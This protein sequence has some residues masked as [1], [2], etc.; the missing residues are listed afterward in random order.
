VEWAVLDWNTPTIGFYQALGA[1]P[2]EGWTTYRLT[3]T[4]LWDLARG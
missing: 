2:D 3:G 4:A 1:Q